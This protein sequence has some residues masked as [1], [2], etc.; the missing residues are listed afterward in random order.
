MKNKYYL[1]DDQVKSLI[2]LINDEIELNIVNGDDAY[3]THWQNIKMAL[4]YAVTK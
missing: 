3:N 4:G 1:T 2:K